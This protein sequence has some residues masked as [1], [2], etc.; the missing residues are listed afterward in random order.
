MVTNLTQLSALNLIGD[1][2]HG[3]IPEGL[4]RLTNLIRL[5]LSYRKSVSTMFNLFLSLPNIQY[6][7]LEGVN[8]TFSPRKTTNPSLSK[9]SLLSI[10]SCSLIE[11]PHFLHYQNNL[12]QL[13]LGVNN[14]S[15]HIPQWF[16]DVT[17]KNLLCLD[18]S[19]NYLTGFEHPQVF[20]PW[21]NLS[22]AF[23]Q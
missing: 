21:V 18:L 4:F 6:L 3:S 23:L 8:L 12:Q 10:V 13:D 22:L 9:F 1:Y 17:R 16:V 15:G 7:G 20:L 2:L 19:D 11:L 14:I 5:Y